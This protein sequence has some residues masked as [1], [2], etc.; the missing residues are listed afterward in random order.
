MVFLSDFD[1]LRLFHVLRTVASSLPGVFPRLRSDRHLFAYAVPFAVT[2]S[3]TVTL[4]GLLG[5][6]PRVFEAKIQRT[7]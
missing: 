6:R 5:C 7:M 2:S 1:W 3:A 4:L